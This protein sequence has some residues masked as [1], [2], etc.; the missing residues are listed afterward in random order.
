M[1]VSIPEDELEESFVRASGP[2]GQ[3]VNKVSSAVQLRFDVAASPSLPDDV[4]ERLIRLAGRKATGDGVIVITA[5][6]FRDQPRNREDARARLA[7]MVEKA[8]VR[9][10]F[11]RPTR[12]TL[13]SKQ[14]RLVAKSTRSDIK[15]GRGRVTTDD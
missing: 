8:R 1:A 10:V 4:K 14:R 9:P 3:N 15:A 6:R 7:E 5:N 12:P 2:G 13:G 11:R